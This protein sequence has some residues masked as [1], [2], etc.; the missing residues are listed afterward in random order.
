MNVPLC[1]G[2]WGAISFTGSAKRAT[3]LATTAI[4]TNTNCT[5]QRTFQAS[6]PSPPTTTTTTITRLDREG[7]QLR[8]K[9]T[10]DFNWSFVSCVLR[11]FPH[12]HQIPSPGTLS[13]LIRHIAYSNTQH[14]PDYIL[15]SLAALFFLPSLPSHSL[16]CYYYY[17]RSFHSFHAAL[18]RLAASF[19]SFSPSEFIGLFLHAFYISFYPF[20]CCS[21]LSFFSSI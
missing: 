8:P 18:V 2:T 9:L 21:F 5:C 4:T 15:L 11:H 16:Y 13:T 1:C 14:K 19:C 3:P 10:L 12:H 7:E 6:H 20:S 17:F